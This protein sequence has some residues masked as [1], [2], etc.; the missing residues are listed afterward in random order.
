MSK[1]CSIQ[2]AQTNLKDTALTNFAGLGKIECFLGLLWID[3]F[4]FVIQDPIWVLLL[5]LRLDIDS[6]VTLGDQDTYREC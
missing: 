4:N 2:K 3:L 1:S 5:D 6:T